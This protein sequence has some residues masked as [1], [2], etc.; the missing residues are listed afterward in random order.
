MYSKL[1]AIAKQILP[2]RFL[3]KNEFLFRKIISLKYQGTHHQCNICGVKLKRFVDLDGKDLL[4]PN[5]GSRSRTRRLH[6]QL[7]KY[8]AL[9]G[10]VLHF[11]PPKILYKQ[12]KQLKINYY[13]SDFENEFTADYNYNIT[14]IPANEN[15]FNTIICYHIL[16]HIEND[17]KAMS[18]LY[19][20][21]K[22]DGIC[23][24]QTPYIYGE[25]K[26]DPSI[27]LPEDRKK[28]FG[29]E[30]HVRI[31]ALADLVSRLK[32]AGFKIEVKSFED[33][34]YNGLNKET[35]ILAT[36]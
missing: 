20:V 33:E 19:R 4:C 17:K 36:K 13:S 15:Y 27:T 25:T 2:K 8:N 12:F 24:I 3:E 18:E 5:C 1:K 6:K 7:L 14:S 26:E 21:L 30:D 29:Q 31:Y 28:H 34:T 32:V 10:N 16:E 23:F 11:S 9:N 22:P 35:L